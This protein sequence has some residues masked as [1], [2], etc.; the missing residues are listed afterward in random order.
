MASHLCGPLTAELGY[1]MDNLSL[2]LR[3][4]RRVVKRSGAGA[5]ARQFATQEFEKL[6]ADVAAEAPAQPP[7]ENL[8]KSAR[9][10]A[11]TTPGRRPRS[12]H[13]T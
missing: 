8:A 2:F 1:G 4:P 12:C 6:K 5:T 11:L 3:Q 7:P 9:A 13:E 10:D